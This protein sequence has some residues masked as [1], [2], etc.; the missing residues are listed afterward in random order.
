MAAGLPDLVDCA[1]LAEDAAVLE[2]VYELRD[3]PRLK[4]VLA[5]PEGVLHA[6]FA[7]SKAAS[8]GAGAHVAVRAVPVLTCQ[9]C[10]QGFAVAVQSASDVE[11]AG[12]ELA[13]PSDAQREV[14]RAE[15]GRVSLRELAE[16]ELLLALPIVPACSTPLTCGNA[17]QRLVDA[18]PPEEAERRPFGALQDLLKKT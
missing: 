11:F 5:Q 17:P 14:F 10:L 4:D 6:K 16:E 3:L 15:G 9:R 8:G 1:R 7:F 12:D 18:S 13:A 2:R